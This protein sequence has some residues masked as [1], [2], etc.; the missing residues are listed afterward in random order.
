MEVILA[1]E[2]WSTWL[3]EEPAEPDE[4]KSLLGTD[5]SSVFNTVATQL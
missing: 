4:L 5:L 3:G 2:T 1:P